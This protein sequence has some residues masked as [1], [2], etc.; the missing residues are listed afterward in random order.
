MLAETSYEFITENVWERPG[1]YKRSFDSVK[2][3]VKFLQ[4]FEDL[5]HLSSFLCRQQPESDRIR[6]RLIR[7]L[8]TLARK[9][10]HLRNA[11]LEILLFARRDQITPPDIYWDDPERFD[12]VFHRNL[13]KYLF[14][15]MEKCN[16]ETD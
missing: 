15:D 1:L 11:V 2:G 10:P 16:R 6:T 8:Y 3:Y 4:S 9:M 14:L 12:E 5:R 7:R 13:M